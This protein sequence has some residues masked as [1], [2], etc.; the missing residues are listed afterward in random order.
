MSSP[1]TNADRLADI[2]DEWQAR[3]RRGEKPDVEEYAARHP[4][5]AGD[6][7]DLLPALAAVEDLKGDALDRTIAP[8]AGADPSDGAAQLEQLGDFRILREVGRGGMGVVYEAEQV[9]LGRRVALKVLPQK[10]LRDPKQKRRFEREA[11]SAAKLHH[12]NIVP[13]FGVGEHDGIPYYVMQFIQGLAL[14]AV[15]QEVKRLHSSG[16]GKAP[17]PAAPTLTRAD[18]SAVDVARSLVTGTF[19][20]GPDS[21]SD[22]RAGPS[23]VPK[24]KSGSTLNVGPPSSGSFVGPG[25]GVGGSG[26]TRS[27][28][29]PQTYWQSVALLGAQ[30]ADALEYAHKQGVLHRDVKP[31]N[32]LLDTRGTVWVTDFGLA[33]ADDQENL[34]HTGDVLGTLRYMP[35]EAFDGRA[36]ARGDVY[37]LG[38]TLYELLAL[39]PAFDEKDRHRLIK[40]VT[41]MEPTRLDR[42]AP[43]IPR[44]LVTIVHKA[45]DR[46]PARR[47]QTAG[48][49]ADDLNRFLADEPIQARRSTRWERTLRW[50]RH[51]PA[52]AGLIAASAIALLAVA[53]A[54][55]VLAYNAELR[56]AKQAA[57]RARQDAEQLRDAEAGQ[58]RLADQARQDAERDRGLAEA[59]RKEAEAERENAIFQRGQ[60]A[61]L[62]EQWA[63]AERDLG[64]Y[65]QKHPDDLRAWLGLGKAQASLNKPAPAIESYTKAIGL[66]ADNLEA[67][68]GRAEQYMARGETAAAVADY[69]QVFVRN[70]EAADHAA[71]FAHAL[72]ADTAGWR[73]LTPTAAAPSKGGRLAIQPD[74]SITPEGSVYQSDEFTLTFKTDLAGIR[75][76]RLETGL[77][78]TRKVNGRTVTSASYTSYALCELTVRAAGPD[79]A[80]Q[81]VRFADAAANYSVPTGAGRAATRP[82]QQYGDVRAAIDDNPDTGWYVYNQ[83]NRPQVAVFTPDRPVGG[84]DGT[85]LTVTLKFPASPQYNQNSL[86]RFRLSASPKSP[87]PAWEC[88]H[89]NPQANAWMKLAAAR[90]VRGEAAAARD[91]LDRADRAT[92]DDATKQ[93]LRLIVRDPAGLKAEAPAL[94]DRAMDQARANPYGTNY[95][96]LTT[97]WLLAEAAAAWAERDP[98]NRQYLRARAEALVALERWGEAAAELT[99]LAQAD[100]GDHRALL[101]RGDCLARSGQAERAV[102]DFEAAARLKPD[103]ALAWL[104]QKAQSVTEAADAR[105]LLPVYDALLK[106]EPTPDRQA[107]ALVR[108]GRAHALLGRKADAQADFARAADLN[109]KSPDALLERGA[110]RAEAGDMGGAKADFA[111]A[112]KLD[113]A[114]AMNWHAQRVN[115]AEYGPARDQTMLLLHLTEL[116]D[117]DAASVNRV[118]YIQRRAYAYQ[119][120]KRYAEAVADYTRVLDIHPRQMYTLMSRADA[121]ALLGDYDRAGA[122]LAEAIRADRA[123][124]LQQVRYR[125]QAAESAR[126]WPMA[127][128]C[129]DALLAAGPDRTEELALLRRRAAARLEL[130]RAADAVADCD[131]VLARVKDDPTALRLKRRA[132]AARADELE[133]RGEPDKARD[134]RRQSRAAL[135]RL[136]EENPAR[137]EIAGELADLLLAEAAG[138]R[139]LDP[140]EL[141]SAGGATLTKQPDG[142]VLA[143]GAN[144]PYDS[145]TLTARGGAAAIRAVRVE[146]IPDPSLPFN[147]P[148]RGA[149]NGN[150]VLS[151]IRVIPAGQTRPAPIA[152]ASASFARSNT[153]VRDAFD[154]RRKSGWGIV[155]E[156]PGQATIG[157]P[158]SAIFS[159]REPIPAGPV[160]STLRVELDFG[161]SAAEDRN[162][163][164]FRLAV[165]ASE[166]AR[167][168]EEIRHLQV[169]PWLKLAAARILLGQKEEAAKALVGKSPK[170]VLKSSA[171]PTAL[172]RAWLSLHLDDG[173]AGRATR[174]AYLAGQRKAGAQ[175]TWHA[176]SLSEDVFARLVQEQPDSTAARHWRAEVRAFLGDDADLLASLDDDLKRNPNDRDDTIERARL[177]LRAHRWAEA[178]ADFRRA[179]ELK[180]DEHFLAFTTAPLILWVGDEEGYARYRTAMLERFGGSTD[181]TI[182]E[183]TAKACLVRPAGGAELAT[184]VKL[185]DHAVAAGAGSDTMPWFLMCQALAS[186]RDGRPKDAVAQARQARGQSGAT[187]GYVECA[188]LLIEA[189]AQHHLG[190]A[191][192]AR[193][194]LAQADD[195]MRTRLP[196]LRETNPGAVDGS[197]H[198]LLICKFLQAEADGKVNADRPREK[199]PRPREVGR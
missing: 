21:P 151:E 63:E 126:S 118:A 116:I 189:L 117:G 165:S 193:R 17:D 74:G 194:L 172:L 109:P 192:D 154:G 121:Y 125:A 54:A 99:K 146:A 72:H 102:A 198:D 185:A 62:T 90:H 86:G 5:L 56:E 92:G 128:A 103:E 177:H 119:Q 178:A 129:L 101:D 66:A 39:R 88:L 12:T 158:Q 41:T 80:P 61:V 161:S 199:G 76:I 113:P 108:R 51:N 70:P 162:L 114:G 163:G 52:A 42:L 55:T 34:T 96:D 47:Y 170:A 19:G 57:E 138:W 152:L 182:A 58:R 176:P 20:A 24:A 26:I 184:A 23:D 29:K 97:R 37:S 197:F 111:A 35:P 82:G 16:S 143:S 77:D 127:V 6:L 8:Q 160:G 71:A 133:A 124:G 1:E 195:V 190:N 141:K 30:V 27:K 32:L 3:L 130:G 94:L 44:D 155:P 18:V 89:G 187:P 73:V 171:T 45:T 15:L 188:T 134:L 84:P 2:V 36:D 91:A 87:G 53:G 43:A 14:D 67:R 65:A 181:V 68:A 175:V 183:R 169:D 69:E 33:K 122:D 95:G 115:R 105:P 159:L 174:R 144:P 81:P 104:R 38:L 79:G 48:A 46:D 9:S 112:R 166:S 4:D 49:L 10:V 64:G 132:E 157:V 136:L 142:S 156:T 7:R 131:Q 22:A 153:P 78:T 148:G 50:M 164:R 59:A 100:P 168:A 196:D 179:V 13:V 107:D 60:L 191:G 11:R 135:E 75:A 173:E 110:L 83:Y 186:Y 140:V 149:T 145:Y 123:N 180:P 98:G 147:G 40:H 25:L 120:Q 85:T 28:A 150:F 139:V 137:G 93:L 106:L 167:Q 31:S